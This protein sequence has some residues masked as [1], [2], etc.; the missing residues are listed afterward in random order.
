M[1]DVIDDDPASAASLEGVPLFPL[2]D[3]TAAVIRPGVSAL[4][5]STC[6]TRRRLGSWPAR[7]AGAWTARATK[8]SSR[9]SRPWRGL[10]R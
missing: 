6:R 2:A 9:G 5:R 10:A 8:R 3:G 1:S 7:R 4:R